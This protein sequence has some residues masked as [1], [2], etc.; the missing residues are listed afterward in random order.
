MP[1]KMTRR[2]KILAVLGQIQRATPRNRVQI[3]ALLNAEAD[4]ASGE[5]DLRYVHNLL[6]RA[7][8]LP[9]IKAAP[10][11]IGWPI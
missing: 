9:V 8:G 1:S 10:P 2:E 6:A 5:P 3:S 4:L 7:W 11:P